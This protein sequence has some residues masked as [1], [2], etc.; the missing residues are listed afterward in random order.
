MGEHRCSRKFSE[1]LCQ[2]VLLRHCIQGLVSTLPPFC[3]GP[4]ALD[5]TISLV[6]L[7][8]L[9]H[10][11]VSA[12]VQVRQD[13]SRRSRLRRRC[14]FLHFLFIRLGAAERTVNLCVMPGGRTNSARICE[15]RSVP[16]GSRCGPGSS[17]PPG[18]DDERASSFAHS[19]T[20]SEKVEAGDSKEPWLQCTGAPS[21]S[22]QIDAGEIGKLQERPFS[23]SFRSISNDRG[24]ESVWAR[25]ASELE[26]GAC[27]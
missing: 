20:A 23:H 7:H 25:C 26:D 22:S 2:G 19:V 16:N 21:R 12:A 10:G 11:I 27:K 1:G 6:L 24:P 17:L 9:L 15:G 18:F 3:S 4:L 8:A 13:A 5:G 14:K